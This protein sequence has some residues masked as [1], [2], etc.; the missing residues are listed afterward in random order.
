MHRLGL[1]IFR[2]DLR[3]ADNTALLRAL[4]ECERVIPAFILDPR[5]A[6][7]KKNPYFSEHAFAFMIDSL[8]ELDG[9]LRQKG[10]RLYV[11]E[12]EPHKVVAQLIEN[13]RVQAVYVNAD[14]TPF[15]RAR[16]ESLT[17]VCKRCRVPFFAC[18]DLTLSPITTLA[19]QQGKPY[20]VFTPFMRNAMTNGVPAPRRNT[21]SN[22]YHGTLV[23]PSITTHLSHK[24]TPLTP[25]FS[26]WERELLGRTGALAILK[27]TAFISKY[28]HTRDLPA[29]HGTSH[30]SPHHKFGTVSIRETYAATRAHRGEGAQQFIAELY[31][32]DF[33]HHITYHFPHVFG[34]SFLPWGDRIAWRNDPA[35]LAAWQRGETGIPIVDA[36]MRELLATGWMHNRVRMIV[37]SFLTKNLL[38]DWRAGEKY[39]AQHLV[40]YDPAVNN[41]GWQW[42]ASV[43]ADPRPLRI[44]NP[45]TQAQKYDPDAEYIKQW[46][47]ELKA[48]PHHLL[49]DGK[50][51]DISALTH[52]YPAPIVSCRESYH[53]AREAYA[54]AKRTW[55]TVARGD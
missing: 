1:H 37:A 30:L 47:P 36:G 52:T 29:R 4:A 34:Q 32:R 17:Q 45:Y 42:S 41:G 31:W 40:D 5:Q 33:Y 9:E 38:I 11:F 2:R 44:F 48:L 15:A 27:S 39:F 21:Y 23:T 13:D 14:Y 19:T 54:H 53:R 12:G 10:S 25:A 35:S 7:P 51:R 26:R 50:E 28:K 8:H 3:L 43:G 55:H 24:S 49:V 18:D 22:Y 20:S 46:V 16:D 6:D